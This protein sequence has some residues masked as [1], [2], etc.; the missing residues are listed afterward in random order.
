VHRSGRIAIL[1][2]LG[3][4]ACHS[5]SGTSGNSGG[6]GSNS[7]GA[8]S[9][10][11]HGSGYDA[12]VFQPTCD[13][14]CQDYLTALGVKQTIDLLFNQNI[15][16]KPGGAI[17]VTGDCPLGGT[18]TI[19]GTIDTT[20][21]GTSTLHLVFMLD[22]C[23]NSGSLY[24]FTLT[25][26]AKEDGTFNGGTRGGSKF[27]AVTLKATS[28]VIEGTLKYSYLDD[29]DVQ[30]T[31][32]I[33]VTDQQSGSDKGTLDGAVCGREYSSTT[34]FDSLTGHR[35]SSG[36]GGSG[37]GGSSGGA[38][39]DGGVGSAGSSAESDAGSGTGS[40]SG[41]CISASACITCTVSSA[42]TDCAAQENCCQIG[43]SGFCTDLTV[44]ACISCS[45]TNDCDPGQLCCF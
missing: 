22:G 2:L 41:L 28:L 34:A 21:D 1:F 5:A 35:G 33:S 29:P 7:G 3:L 13:Q 12:A 42:D 24:S 4:A 30:E 45:D 19:T 15:A 43:S 23:K 32:P 10:G 38:A 31:C 44:G 17:N 25:G 8:G 20:T 9:N 18:A 6:A 39:A 11:S 37:S 36:N 27:S 16:G 14:T 40:K 26:T